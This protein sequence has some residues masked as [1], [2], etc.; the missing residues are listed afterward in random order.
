MSIFCVNCGKQLRE[1]AKF[2][3]YCGAEVR[4][5]KVPEAPI[6]GQF[7]AYQGVPQNGMPAA[8]AGKPQSTYQ[9]GPQGPYY[10]M[11]AGGYMNYTQAPKKKSRAGLITAIIAVVMAAV[12]AFTGF[13]TPGFFL[14]KQ[15]EAQLP[16]GADPDVYSRINRV[17]IVLPEPGPGEAMVNMT[18]DLS[19]RYYIVARMYLE[20]L[21]ACDPS[22]VDPDEYAALLSDTITAF[23]NADAASAGLTEAVDLWL[24]SDEEMGKPTYTIVSE[25]KEGSAFVGPFTT[26]AYAA[27]DSEAVRW[28]KQVTEIFDKA[29]AGTGVRTLAA[30]MNTDA[31]HAYAQLRQAQAIL[32]GADYED[33]A[34]KADAA[35]KTATVLKTA[36][37]V[38]GCVIAAAPV[39][40]GSLATMGALE[41]TVTVGGV[42]TSGVNAACEVTSTGAMLAYG[43]EDN[44]VSQTADGI[45]KDFAPVST[46][47]SLAG[48]GYNAK[49]LLEKMNEADRFKSLAEVTKDFFKTEM[50]SNGG[51]EASDAFGVLSFLGGV[52]ADEDSMKNACILAATP[53]MGSDGKVHVTAEDTKIG[54][55]PEEQKAMK[56]VLENAGVPASEAEETVKKAVQNIEEAEQRGEK[57]QSPVTPPD[58]EAPIPQETIDEVLE[59]NESLRPGSDDFDIQEYLDRLREVLY[60]IA[61]LEDETAEPTSEE[62]PGPETPHGAEGLAGTYELVSVNN[63]GMDGGTYLEVEYQDDT[64]MVLHGAAASVP[65]TFDPASLTGKSEENVYSDEE[66]DWTS[67]SYNEFKFSV[68]ED[69]SVRLTQTL[70]I[71]LGVGYYSPMDTYVLVKVD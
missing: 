50:S 64:H 49:H 54:T 32:E 52:L 35:V 4:F 37:T 25:A 10:G 38:A 61:A 40:A 12:L 21:L 11:P 48:L 71:D 68:G 46:I 45:Q 5:P 29:K 43:T 66:I 17:E 28:A 69:G 1:D 7:N 16:A 53:K 8:P 33:I 13:V 3:R 26:V 58:P 63:E 36:G 14:K 42:I 55:S 19:L 62:V 47:V 2:C 9:S 15:A 67:K 65:F 59:E 41:A 20:K 6:N 30:H 18:T 70:M 57:P 39:A 51:K 22:A 34:S 60:E 24:E 44:I 27:K 56:Q 31:K 23:E